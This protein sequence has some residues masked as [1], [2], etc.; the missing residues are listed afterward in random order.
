MK[1]VFRH[2]VGLS[3]LIVWFYGQASHVWF[4]VILGLSVG[5]IIFKQPSFE[6]FSFSNVEHFLHFFVVWLR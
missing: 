6:S 2:L 3:A 5:Q 4:R 1:F